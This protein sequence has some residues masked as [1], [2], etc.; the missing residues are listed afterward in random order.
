MKMMM[1]MM[2]P[3]ASEPRVTKLA[4]VWTT[5]PG[6]VHRRG[7][8]AVGGE[9]QPGRGDVQHQPE[10]RD[11]QQQRRETREFQRALHV[12]RRHQHDDRQRDVADQQQ[13]QNLRRQRHEDHQQQAD[14]RQRKEHPAV[15]V[16]LGEDRIGCDAVAMIS[17]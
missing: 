1:K 15:V 10:E 16:N 9:N 11:R 4:N 8:V 7:G 3:T 12:D 6:G 2:M 17:C 13:I 14:E 5:S